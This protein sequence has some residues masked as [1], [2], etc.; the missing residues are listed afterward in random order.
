MTVQQHCYTQWPHISSAYRSTFP[1][2]VQ[3]VL[4]PLASLVSSFL[5]SFSE[6]LDC[7]VAVCLGFCCHAT[8]PSFYGLGSQLRLKAAALSHQ[9]RRDLSKSS[10]S[11]LERPYIRDFVSSVRSTMSSLCSLNRRDVFLYN[12]C[13]DPMLSTICYSFS[14]NIHVYISTIRVLSCVSAR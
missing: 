14:Q 5:G 13:N 7:D 1:P 11:W 10:C 8:E 2:P 6:V 12:F 4:L 9:M 3:A